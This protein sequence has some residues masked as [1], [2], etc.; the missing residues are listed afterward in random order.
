MS[1][2][3]EPSCAFLSEPGVLHT[4]CSIISAIPTGFWAAAFASLLT[5]AGV[6]LSNR[7]NRQ[8]LQIRTQ[9]ESE[10]NLK[11]RKYELRR[12]IYFEISE[13]LASM[14]TLLSRLSNIPLSQFDGSDVL[15]RM[16][17]ATCKVQIVADTETAELAGNLSTE[18]GLLWV[19]GIKVARPSQQKLDLLAGYRENCQTAKQEWLRFLSILTEAQAQKG[20]K[21]IRE[22]WVQ[23]NADYW[24][25][26]Y[27]QE[28][29]RLEAPALDQMRDNAHYIK[30]FIEKSETSYE[31][32]ATLMG[33]MRSELEAGGDIDRF[34]RIVRENRAKIAKA[35][36]EL[37]EDQLNQ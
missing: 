1:T 3:P 16:N 20:G 23:N 35:I 18:I 27:Q 4:G 34:T 24:K 22:E 8:Q 2:T 7:N 10:E 36:E 26:N 33:R 30:W 37:I 28:Q 25:D 13:A 31:Q 32:M 29:K 6:F 12:Q 9:A 19:E 5:L 17:A 15:E 11:Q 14:N 21:P